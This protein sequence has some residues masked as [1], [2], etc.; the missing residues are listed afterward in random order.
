LSLWYRLWLN[1]SSSYAMK[2]NW[3]SQH[4]N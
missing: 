3:T 2:G 1:R 4:K